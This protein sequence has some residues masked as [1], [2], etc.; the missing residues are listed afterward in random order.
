MTTRGLQQIIDTAQSIE[1]YRPRMI[2]QMVVRSGRI[3][4]AER[5]ALT[6]FQMIVAPQAYSR[7]EDVR[8]L[9]EGITVVDRNLNTWVKLSNTTGMN[10]ITEYRGD[11]TT[12]QVDNLRVATT[13]TTATIFGNQDFDTSSIRGFTTST[14]FDY[15]ELSG[16]PAIGATLADGTACTTAS[17]IFK[18]GDWIQLRTLASGATNWGLAR[19]I[20]LDVPRGSGTTVKVPVNRRWVN[21]NNVD[22]RGGDIY[23][24]NAIR[25][26]M[27][28][29]RMPSFKLLPGRIVQWTS[30]FELLEDIT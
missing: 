6:P 21:A 7:W 2:S 30:D 22:R 16:I 8:D 19:T 20:P 23:V 15:V 5:T 3:R 26:R 12:A 18:A 11:L 10:Y 14:N 9:V 25:L 1:V 29:T 27:L 17:N 4:T 28:I 13:G 24:G